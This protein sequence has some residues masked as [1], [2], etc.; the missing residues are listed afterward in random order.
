MFDPS[1]NSAMQRMGFGDAPNCAKCGLAMTPE[2]SKRRPELF[3]HDECLPDELKEAYDSVEP[4]HERIVPNRESNC[5]HCGKLKASEPKLENLLRAYRQNN[6]VAFDEVVQELLNAGA[7]LPEDLQ[8]RV[9]Q[10]L[11]SNQQYSW[12]VRYGKFPLGMVQRW[13][14]RAEKAESELKGK[15]NG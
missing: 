15:R 3:L 14:E 12:E 8:K 1:Y 10:W 7:F 11:T 13:I 5:R 9:D 2:N 6:D 4:A